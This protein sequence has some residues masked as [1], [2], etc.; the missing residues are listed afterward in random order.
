MDR[1]PCDIF[2]LSRLIPQAFILSWF[3]ILGQRFGGIALL[4]NT[5]FG[6]T[7]LPNGKPFG[8]TLNLNKHYFISDTN[9]AYEVHRGFPQIQTRL[10][11]LV[12]EIR[13]VLALTKYGLAN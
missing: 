4:N 3:N 6:S 10:S 9:T 8:G 7:V 12:H 13:S 2:L 1:C 11:G 5:L